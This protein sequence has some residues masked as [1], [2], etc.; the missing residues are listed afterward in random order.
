MNCQRAE[1]MFIEYL[2][3]ELEPDR[4]EPLRA[5]LDECLACRTR[6]AE[7][8]RVRQMV[9][10]VPGAEPPP[11]A[12]NRV[13]PRAREAKE[14]TQSIWGLR[15]VKVLAPVCLA[16]VIGGLVAY[17]FR[18]GLAPKPMVYAPAKEEQRPTAQEP[19]PAPEP[20]KKSSP[21]A[22]RDA[23]KLTALATAKP[24]SPQASLP[25]PPT[26]ESG[27]GQAAPPQPAADSAA[28]R[29]ASRE[30]FTSGRGEA[31][32]AARLLAQTGGA[33]RPAAGAGQAPVA[34]AAPAQPKAAV[35]DKAMPPPAAG[36]KLEGSISGLLKAGERSLEAGRYWE[37]SQAFSQALKLLQPGD[38]DRPR[39][40]LGL[41]RAQE[42]QK[43][44][45]TAIQTYRELA[46]ESS[47]HRDLAEQKIQELSAK[48]K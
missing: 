15:W 19:I 34:A 24:A 39:A 38:P 23:G 45:T 32:P 25:P 26:A 20:A 22:A 17:Q 30:A 48:V 14:R 1:D 16:V 13:T 35:R 4:A 3:G 33:E 9:A 29:A 31:L 27:A 5:H 36:E 11:V 28:S 2:Y 10:Q 37:A 47:A 7:L 46:Q 44:L 21:P 12:T 43:D 41:A 6:L 40:L 8:A 42:G 18:A